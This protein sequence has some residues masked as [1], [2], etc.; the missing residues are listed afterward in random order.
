LQIISGLDEIIGAFKDPE[1]GRIRG[2]KSSL[3]RCSRIQLKNLNP[4]PTTVKAEPY[5]LKKCAWRWEFKSP[6][7]TPRSKFIKTGRKNRSLGLMLGAL[8]FAKKGVKFGQ[9]AE[10]G[11]LLK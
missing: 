6:V 4:S 7:R 3:E 1:K 8:E 2:G 10:N 5:R 9:M 11:A